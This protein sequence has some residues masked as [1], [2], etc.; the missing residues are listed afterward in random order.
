MSPARLQS[1]AAGAALPLES[2]APLLL[3]LGSQPSGQA[4]SQAPAR[5]KKRDRTEEPAA[6][7]G[8][9]DGAATTADREP[10]PPIPSAAPPSLPAIAEAVLTCACGFRGDL[11]KF[12]GHECLRATAVA[13]GASGADGGGGGDGDKPF[14]CGYCDFKAAA[15]GTLAAHERTHTGDKPYGCRFCDYR[16]V[17]KSNLTR[18]ERAH[19]GEKPYSCS[20]CEY[21]ALRKDEITVRVGPRVCTAACARVYVRLCGCVSARKLHCC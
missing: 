16:A 2:V 15:K 8:R 6:A 11:Q 12:G 19:V 3:L 5:P 9:M 1:R 14:D 20:H 21:R 13:A 7:A 10:D 18:H 4:T 17:Q